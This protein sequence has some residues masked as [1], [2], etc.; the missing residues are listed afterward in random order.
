MEQEFRAV[1]EQHAGNRQ[2]RLGEL[3]SDPIGDHRL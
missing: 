1:L 2:A 3:G